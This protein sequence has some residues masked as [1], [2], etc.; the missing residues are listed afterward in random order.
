MRGKVLIASVVASFMLISSHSLC[1]KPAVPPTKLPEVML[2]PRVVQPRPEPV[3][4][5][6]R[7]I[8]RMPLIWDQG[9]KNA[10]KRGD[11]PHIKVL[12]DRGASVNA[13]YFPNLRTVLH[14]AARK[15]RLDIVEFLIDGCVREGM[16]VRGAK[17]DSH[18]IKGDT[19]LF[20]A[21]LSGCIPTA[22][23]L[24][25]RGAN[26]NARNITGATPIFFAIE[27]A[28]DEK[29]FL[30]FIDFL[31]ANRALLTVKKN[32]MAT[33]LIIAIKKGRMLIV[34]YLLKKLPKT[35]LEMKTAVGDTS[36][37]YAIK[38]RQW[39]IAKLLI[40]KGADVQATDLIGQSPIHLALLYVKAPGGRLE[41][42]KLLLDKGAE[43][44][45]TDST[46]KT[47]LHIAA[48]KG[49]FEII[50][51]LAPWVEDINV[52]DAAHGHTALHL[53]TQ[54]GYLPIVK[55]LL[56]G[57]PEDKRANIEVKSAKGRRPMHV[58]AENGKMAVVQYL[59]SKGAK[60]RPKDSKKET[61][62]SL[63]RISSAD[64]ARQVADFLAA[65]YKEYKRKR[66]EARKK[67]RAKREREEVEE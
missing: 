2:P 14:E 49:F 63:A 27:F 30:K 51:L 31:V 19:P 24:I 43:P 4:S 57:L 45:P 9:L 56:E 17:V 40:N 25:L 47:P 53:A 7:F 48:E 10:V 32:N 1:Q 42:V 6:R 67:A 39:P 55:Y 59:I 26:V 20:Y 22:E 52:K 58:A 62:E 21:A 38:V 64:G 15:C 34:E 33:P 23:Y 37:L 8:V 41:L 13:K 18:N 61:P 35:E 44:N 16:R 50:K 66:A 36:L 54:N 60:I 3:P 65:K 5:K 28:K 12:V 29:H 46:G 11:L